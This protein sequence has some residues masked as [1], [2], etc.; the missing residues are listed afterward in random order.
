MSPII[1]CEQ[2][3]EE[4]GSSRMYR[5]NNFLLSGKRATESGENL[6]RSVVLCKEVSQVKSR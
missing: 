3:T 4:H 6:L 1:T 5:N 2:A